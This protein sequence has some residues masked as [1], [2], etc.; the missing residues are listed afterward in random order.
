M[1][2]HPDDEAD[3]TAFIAALTD[4][5]CW[6]PLAQCTRARA[7]AASRRRRAPLSRASPDATV[8]S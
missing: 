7:D 5:A 2:L 3:V 4:P 8:P 1:N 6:N